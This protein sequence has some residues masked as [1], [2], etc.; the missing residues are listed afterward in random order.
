MNQTAWLIIKASFRAQRPLVRTWALIF[1]LL[2]VLCPRPLGAEQSKARFF[3]IRM[4]DNIIGYAVVGRETTQRNGR[5]VVQLKSETSLKFAMLGKERSTLLDSETLID[6]ETQRPLTYRLTSKTNKVVGHVESQFDKDVVLNW[7]F[8]ADVERGDPTE[9]KLPKGVVVLGSNNFAHWQLLLDAARREAKDN[10]ATI[11]VFLPDGGQVETFE[12]E[13]GEAEEIALASG[14]RS[15]VPWRLRKANL[16]AWVDAK[17]YEFVALWLPSQK[18]KIELANEGIVKLA[19][20]S[21]AEE[22]LAGHFSQSNVLFDDFLAVSHMVAKIDVRV[23]GSGIANK[24]SVLKTGMQEFEGTKKVDHVVGV[25]RITSVAY[26]PSTS[27]AFPTTAEPQEKMA[28]WLAPSDFVESDDASIV[29][30]SKQLTAGAK[31]RWEAVKKIGEWVSE[32]IAYTIADTPSARLALKNKEGDCGPHSTLAVALMR[33][34]GIPARL[35]GGL[36]YTPTFGGSFGQ[37]AWVEVHMGGSGWLAIDPT[38]GEFAKMSATHI[39]LFEGVG[40]V[41]PTSISVESYQPPNRQVR[42]FTAAKAKPIAWK[43]DKQYTFNFSQ[44]D[45][46][47]GTE[48]FTLKAVKRDGKPALELTSKIKLRIN[49]LSSLTSDT[50]LVVAPNAL[51]ISFERDLSALLQKV[52]IE[53]DFKD[54]V[55]AVKTSGTTSLSRDVKISPGTY[56]FDNNLMGCFALICSQLDLKPSEPVTIQTFHPSSLQIIPL[57]FT[58]KPLAPIKIGEDEVECYECEVMPIK[59]TFWIS[60]DGRFVRAQ[61]GNLVIELSE[62]D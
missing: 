59:N 8:A 25:V 48:S 58:A 42:E 10:V 60:K 13:R 3:S 14:K 22:V 41:L 38:T 61:Q 27:P 62:V 55:V 6:S 26:D 35:V 9:I 47:L 53:C 4:N 36:V 57:T 50:T 29:A 30:L 17:T 45:K 11:A 54:G 20:K 15:C 46:A 34:A 37:H 7:I 52:K 5:P 18:T 44:G 24:A 32:E 28:Q 31:T 23:I 43:L 1:I 12:L 16:E 21:R 51:P 33:S 39:K 40:G 56:C 2:T 49:F 19:Q